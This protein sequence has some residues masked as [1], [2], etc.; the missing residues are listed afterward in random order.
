MSDKQKEPL[1]ELYDRE[2]FN[3]MSPDGMARL[4]PDLAGIANSELHFWAEEQSTV[5]S[6]KR[7]RALARYELDRRAEAARQKLLKETTIIG[8]AIGAGGAIAGAILG[9]LLVTIF[10]G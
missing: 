1:M 2:G 4:E 6:H 5:T 3:A 9:A 7:C 10:T 8:G